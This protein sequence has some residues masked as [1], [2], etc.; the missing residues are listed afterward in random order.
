MAAPG[1]DTLAELAEAT[2]EDLDASDAAD[3]EFVYVSGREERELDAQ[4]DLAMQREEAAA[5]SPYARELKELEEEGAMPLEEILQR[6]GLQAAQMPAKTSSAAA[7][8][9]SKAAGTVNKISGT[10]GPGSGAVSAKSSSGLVVKIPAASELIS[11]TLLITGSPRHAAEEMKKRTAYLKQ[12]LKEVRRSK[13]KGS[14]LL[15]QAPQL[16]L[17][18]QSSDPKVHWDFM[19]AELRWMRDDFVNERKWKKRQAKALMRGVMQ[20]HRKK[21]LEKQ[22]KATARKQKQMRRCRMISG[23]VKGFWK[24]VDKITRF[25][26]QAE[27]DSTR[28]A[29]M[30]KRLEF[31]IKQTEMYAGLLSSAEGT[32]YTNNAHSHEGSIK[33]KAFTINDK[34]ILSGSER[35]A[36][37]GDYELSDASMDDETTLAEAERQMSGADYKD[38]INALKRESEM[39]IEELRAM[40]GGGTGEGAGGQ[41]VA[42]SSSS[43]SSAASSLVAVSGAENAED[44]DDGDYELS[45]ASMDDETTLAEAERQ[46]SGADYKDEINALKRESEMSIEELRAMYGGGTGEGA[47]GQGVASGS[48]HRSVGKATSIRSKKRTRVEYTDPCEIDTQ[49]IDA[50]ILEC[51]KHGMPFLMNPSLRLREYQK[52]GVNWL[53][54]MCNR[55]LN[56]I[57]A[58]EM[59]LGKTV[60]TISMLSHIACEK[61]IW[62]PHLI[63]VPT[64]VLLNWEMEFKKFCPALKVLTYYGS[65]KARK[66]KRKGWTSPHA[67]HVCITS[68]Q[69]AVVDANV[70][71]RKQWYFM[72]LDEA[73]NIKNFKS[74]RWNTLLHFNTQRRLLLTGTPL[75]NSMMEL[76]SLLHFLMPH[77]FD[78]MSEFKYWFSNPLTS[79]VEGKAGS[80][81]ANSQIIKRL[82]GVIR[83]FILRRLKKDVAK[84]LPS[85]IEHIVPSH[86]SR[87]QKFLYED[88]MSRSSTRNKLSKGGY[89]GQMSVLMSLRKVCNHPDLFEERPIVSPFA[90]KGISQRFPSIVQICGSFNRNPF[91]SSFVSFNMPSLCNATPNL[92]R[93]STLRAIELRA[94]KNSILNEAAGIHALEIHDAMAVMETKGLA[95]CSEVAKKNIAT[96]VTTAIGQRTVDC[97][98]RA[99]QLAQVNN[100]R[101]DP[102]FMALWCPIYSSD[103]CRAVHVARNAVEATVST[104]NKLQDYFSF[105]NTLLLLVKYHADRI[106][107]WED[108]LRR[109][110]IAIPPA[111]APRPR[112]HIAYIKP[113]RR[114]YEFNVR[115][116]V[117]FP[118]KWLV[119]YD[120]GKLQT[121]ARL[122]AKLKAGGH[123]CL[124]FTQMTK[125]LNVLERFLCLH[126]HTYFRLDG[127][128]NVEKRQRM[129]DRFN[130]DEKVF[131]FI[132]ST[133]SGGLGINL[134][135]ADSVIF[136]D[137]DWNPAMDAQAQDRAHRIGQTRDVHI[138]R[139]V[140]E[141]TIEENILTKANQ[142]RQMNMLAIEEGNFSTEF[143][144]TAEE[145]SSKDMKDF[146][147]GTGLNVD[148]DSKAKLSSADIEAARAAAEDETD[149]SAASEVRKERIGESAVFDETRRLQVGAAAVSSASS[150]TTTTDAQNAA[151]EDEAETAEI[152]ANL[153][154]L[155]KGDSDAMKTLE[156]ALRPIDQYALRFREDVDPIWT[157]AEAEAWRQSELGN[158]DQREWDIEELQRR[159]EQMEKDAD[160]S[161]DMVLA[162]PSR[163]SP[164]DRKR[165]F[166]GERS[167]IDAIRKRRRKCRPGEIVNEWGQNW[168]VEDGLTDNGWGV[169]PK[170]PSVISLLKYTEESRVFG[171]LEDALEAGHE[172]QTLCFEPGKHECSHSIPTI[173]FPLRIFAGNGHADNAQQIESASAAHGGPAKPII[174]G[175]YKTTTTSSLVQLKLNGGPIEVNCSGNVDMYGISVSGGNDAKVS[176]CVRVV[177]G[178]FN[179]D[180]C[181]FSNEGGHGGCLVITGDDGGISAHACEIKN[182]AGAGLSVLKGGAHVSDC[183]ISGGDSFG[184]AVGSDGE[185]TLLK[186]EIS[187]HALA[188][189]RIGG[190]EKNVALESNYIHDNEGG[191]I[192]HGE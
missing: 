183:L 80:N 94:H 126:G 66:E 116:R 188:G 71:R 33:E 64:S 162:A 179:V 11:P 137:T 52:E 39:S 90:M 77:V 117:F 8:A 62:G 19:L 9:R 140:T 57:L 142:K 120:C 129:M 92:S 150:S 121:L 145:T 136:Y 63:I 87:R 38:E 61:G 153:R 18:A 125:M 6:Y 69:L 174:R 99:T 84:Q 111:S 144:K 149:R 139:L 2:D 166:F 141:H 184:V 161:S 96:S 43:S 173:R 113:W 36:D 1:V 172:G 127:A 181:T 190:D 132:L 177:K 73:Q 159:K 45:D 72:I 83:P 34:G 20:M 191:V 106:G 135:G 44:A 187:N 101:V 128:T 165:V 104:Q 23:Q 82:H 124:I 59:G 47:G 70:F 89:M 119:Q 185:A 102:T 15:R 118:D 164:S 123:R 107:E 138:Y 178:S 103:L 75:Q 68:Y 160:C 46:M 182:A 158:A 50:R 27:I 112:A 86:L 42:S 28:K 32:G 4:D 133:R 24:K 48:S 189:V 79:M 156:K 67:F 29:A 58:D 22:R 134:V 114:C 35:E 115:H 152:E 55:K 49:D 12:R 157:K 167:K 56:G 180:R 100:F 30:D 7:P 192:V 25:K 98:R 10:A 13:M 40:Y 175:S 93:W 170:H 31:I 148:I 109:F 155:W 16:P 143:F 130:R 91:N 60:Q 147:V 81:G 85:K 95:Q 3:G 151:A 5:G 146:F 53:V 14:K 74:Q 78:S 176:Q 168:P 88:F 154:K 54:S 26:V 122:L 41:G 186:N 108:R 110:T 17:D 169:G 97:R 171:S 51:S 37:D 105:T 163:S 131:S 76:W 65:T 21:T